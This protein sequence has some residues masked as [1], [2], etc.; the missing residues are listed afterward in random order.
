MSSEV[1]F[2]VVP[3]LALGGA[4]LMIVVGTIVAWRR[5]KSGKRHEDNGLEEG[6]DWSG[7]SSRDR[8]D[9]GGNDSGGDGGG[10]GD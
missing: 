1:A 2:D 10:G 5:R 8:Y 6:G 3:L 9:E 4:G 7:S